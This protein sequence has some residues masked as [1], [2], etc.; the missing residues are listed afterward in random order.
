MD[1]KEQKNKINKWGYKI[2]IIY[3]TPITIYIIY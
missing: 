3:I 2:K 1:V